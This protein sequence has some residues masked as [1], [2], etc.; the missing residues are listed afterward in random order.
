MAALH[1]FALNHWHRLAI[2][3][4]VE[5]NQQLKSICTKINLN[6][7]SSRA[8]FA[9]HNKHATRIRRLTMICDARCRTVIIALIQSL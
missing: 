5:L 4:A 1:T 9:T 2:D 8:S 6:A 3:C 7:I